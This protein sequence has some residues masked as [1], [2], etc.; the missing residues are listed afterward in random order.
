MRLSEA[1]RL[2]FVR[3]R[4]EDWIA[5]ANFSHSVEN[6]SQTSPGRYSGQLPG[7][8]SDPGFWQLA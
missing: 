8:T 4:L 5:I 7:L 6:L 2:T 1:I 3:S